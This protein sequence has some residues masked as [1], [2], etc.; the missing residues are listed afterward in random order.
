MNGLQLK[1]LENCENKEDK[2]CK[3]TINLTP[4][5]RDM[6]SV[7]FYS[8]SKDRIT[9]VNRVLALF[10]TKI[11]GKVLLKVNLVSNELYPTTTHPILLE[12]VLK[13]LKG[14]DLVVGD[15]HAVDFRNFQVE[16]SPLFQIC[17]KYHVPF[18]D[19]YQTEMQTLKSSREY[20]FTATCYP[21]SC[22]YIISLP[23][24]KSH[25]QVHMSGALKN[26]FGYLDKRDRILMHINK[27]NIHQGI[28]ELNTF[29][30]PNLTIMDA[31]ETL[32]EAQEVRHGGIKQNL[33]YLIAGEDPVALDIFSFSLLK[34]ISPTW[35]ITVPQDIPYIKY[36]LDFKIGKNDYQAQEI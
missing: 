28:A 19:F 29:F 20:E 26:A 30:K 34:K 10:R 6:K 8:K 25:M 22:N 9:F 31:I 32:I 18:I 21:F 27:K 12:T 14:L 7:I 23:V 15:A 24:L 36:A 17:E 5:E 35:K 33:G 16:G 2:N 4:I 11:T 3:K 13:A 1:K